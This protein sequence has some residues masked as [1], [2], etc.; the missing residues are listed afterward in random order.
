MKLSELETSLKKSGPGPLYVV[1]GEED[2]LR[3]QAVSTL[4]PSVLG[5]HV[6]DGLNEDL[7]YGDESVASEILGCA[8][9]LPAF[10]NRRWVLVKGADKLPARESEAVSAYLKDPNAS[11]TLVFS[12][13]KLDGRTKLTQALKKYCLVV[14]CG[15]L[16][17]NQIPG[18]IVSQARQ[19][20]IQVADDAMPLL[21]ELAG[22]SL[23]FAKR[24]LEKLAAA[25]GEG[26]IAERAQVEALRGIEPG[27]SVFD[28]SSAIGAGDVTR[29]LRIVVKNIESGEAP[30]RIL[31]SFV[32]QYRRLWKGYRLRQEGRSQGDIVKVLGIPPFRLSDF[33][34][35]ISRFSDE[36]FWMAFPLFL[37]A[38]S[39]LKGGR[40]TDPKRVIEELVLRLC[41]EKTT[42]RSESLQTGQLDTG[43]T[44]SLPHKSGKAKTSRSISMV[45]T[46]QSSNQAPH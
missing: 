7:F 2:W 13:Q 17:A 24:E 41:L 32:W 31:G 16:P 14:D 19:L 38:D 12:A 36:H 28:L 34:K 26:T 37:E 1:V 29:A 18:W 35:E 33:M 3:D 11:T 9:D 39:T 15:A 20:G 22:Q 25:L 6:L 8:R 10:G 27:A 5:D 4:K 21:A 23:N 43:P 45:R 40:A 42:T 30:L 44:G 46:I